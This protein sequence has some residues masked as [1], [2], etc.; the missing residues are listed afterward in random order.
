M[1]ALQKLSDEGFR[2]VVFFLIQRMDAKLFRPARELDPAYTE[3]LQK[4]DK[5]GVEVMAYDVNL[6]LTDIQIRRAIAVEL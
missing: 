4:A 1:A 5:A 6:T 2:A 3:A